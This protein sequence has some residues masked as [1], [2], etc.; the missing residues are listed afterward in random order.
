MKKF[1]SAILW[2]AFVSIFGSM[3]TFANEETEKDLEMACRDMMIENKIDDEDVSDFL[4]NCREELGK[5]EEQSN[6]EVE[7]AHD[8]EP[9]DIEDTESEENTDAYKDDTM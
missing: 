1:L 6:I 9:S 8:D 5:D 2:M 7:S 3:P 4:N